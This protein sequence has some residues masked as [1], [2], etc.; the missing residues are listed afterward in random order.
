MNIEMIKKIVYIIFYASVVTLFTWSIDRLVFTNALFPSFLRIEYAFYDTFQRQAITEEGK[1]TRYQAYS[2]VLENLCFVDF[3]EEYIDK[4]TGRIN[5]DS[6]LQLLDLI[7]SNTGHTAIFLDYLFINYNDRERWQDSMLIE[8]F[9]EIEDKL[10][11]PYLIKYPSVAINQKLNLDSITDNKD[12]LLFKGGTQGYI[13]NGG[14]LEDGNLRYHRFVINNKGEDSL[15]SIT[16]QLLNKQ[17]IIFPGKTMPSF[18]ET[19][20]LVIAERGPIKL[21]LQ[22]PEDVKFRVESGAWKEDIKD[23][24]IIVGL[25]DKVEDHYGNSIDQ[26]QVPIDEDM[27]GVL[28]VINNYLNVAANLYLKKSP[29]GFVFL[30]NI[31][32][33]L[34]V[35]EYQ[36]F[37]KKKERVKTLPML[38]LEV[39]LSI[40]IFYGG[41]YYLY[42]HYAMKFPFVVSSVFFVR[43]KSLYYWFTGFYEKIQNRYLPKRSVSNS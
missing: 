36:V 6:L 20:Y 25:F 22:S 17:P 14:L 27:N 11:L 28:V 42:F 7:T 40:L 30:V 16:K 26:H 29:I 4:E 24:I 9:K 31:F 37:L 21:R 43:N 23:K 34:V 39:G 18:F 32:I 35:L 12:E 10:V 2:K 5:K 1:S 8:K 41:L 15:V 19:N 38:I 3:G 33:A 13:D